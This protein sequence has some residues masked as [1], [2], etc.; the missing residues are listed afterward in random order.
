[1]RPGI[2]PT[3]NNSIVNDD[4]TMSTEEESDS[5]DSILTKNSISINKP[6]A[7]DKSNKRPH[8]PTITTNAKKVADINEGLSELKTLITDLNLPKETAN[9][10]LEKVDTLGN[11]FKLL[12]EDLH[13]TIDKKIEESIKSSHF[14][15]EIQRQIELIA[16]PKLQ[17]I[18]RN[19]STITNN[20]TAYDAEFPT[21]PPLT[22]KVR[23]YLKRAPKENH[24]QSTYSE[25][26][27]DTLIIPK[28]TPNNLNKVIIRSKLD[29]E[30]NKISQLTVAAQLNKINPAAHKINFIY[31]TVQ[32]DG[33][34]AIQ[35]TSKNDISKFTSLIDQRVLD[36]TLLSPNNPYINI[37]GIEADITAEE[38]QETL[39]QILGEYPKNSY[40]FPIRPGK[41][42]T[43]AS[44]EV[45]PW[46]WRHLM[47]L[48]SIRI[49]WLN[50]KIYN[51][52]RVRRCN[53]CLLY[54]HGNTR[55]TPCTNTDAKK[56][57]DC[58]AC[59]SYNT[60]HQSEDVPA[61][62]INHRFNDQCCT[63]FQE[64]SRLTVLRTDYKSQRPPIYS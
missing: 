23:S 39:H 34:V 43:S 6:T 4:L 37:S 18:R 17:A 13:S 32:R 63:S 42:F 62:K 24:R 47:R 3:A 46:Q 57:G 56:D 61:R 45:F 48:G 28:H 19:N 10:I 41:Q 22:D 51:H 29:A 54:G 27:E 15:K 40:V 30:G 20:Q 14:N 7:I 2:S 16:K 12:I 36:I 44:V 60:A 53:K 25:A 49:R 58:P 9:Q 33:S 55:M 21:L 8:S 1:M 11:N 31:R 59:I 50:C 5:G 64:A 35:F 26:V 52:V 38:L